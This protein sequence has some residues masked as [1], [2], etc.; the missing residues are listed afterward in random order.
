MVGHYIASAL[1]LNSFDM[2]G[3]IEVGCLQDFCDAATNAGYHLPITRGWEIIACAYFASVHAK[4][5]TIKAGNEIQDFVC[6]LA[7]FW[8]FHMSF[9]RL[10]LL[11][12]CPRET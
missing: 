8:V 10:N 5:R 2:P 9:F 3:V 6:R 11:C 7:V 1:V 4:A 12:L